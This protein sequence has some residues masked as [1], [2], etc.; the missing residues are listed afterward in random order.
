MVKI[1]VKI[2]YPNLTFKTIIIVI[3]SGIEYD[4]QVQFSVLKNLIQL[5]TVLFCIIL[6][7]RIGFEWLTYIP[8]F[9][10]VLQNLYHN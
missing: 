2:I 6:R 1:E 5:K 9:K 8:Q 10:H 4:M 7:W 3:Y